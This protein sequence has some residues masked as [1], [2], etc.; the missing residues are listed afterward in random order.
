MPNILRD[1]VIVKTD[2]T[3]AEE[4]LLA[5]P[6]LSKFMGTLK[7]EQEKDNFRKH[8]R[9]YI[10]I[11]KPDCPFEVASTNRY[12]VVTHEA[13]VTARQ[14]IKKG[15]TIKYLTGIQISLSDEEMESIKSALRDFSIVV[16]SRKK[17]TSLFLGPA[18]FAN[19]D[20]NANARLLTSG[21]DGMDIVAHKDIQIGDEITVSYGPY[22]HVY[23]SALSDTDS[24]RGLF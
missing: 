14:F 9:K 12:T 24:R 10:N 6:A 11:Y 8:L 18:R 19:H 23:F 17:S 21:R 16:S 1:H 22:S 3:T 15:Q 5:L 4:K 20:C 7:A 2:T 13:S